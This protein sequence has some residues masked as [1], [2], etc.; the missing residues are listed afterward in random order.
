MDKR[1]K[2]WDTFKSFIKPLIKS[3][4]TGEI[5]MKVKDGVI[6]GTYATHIKEMKRDGT[7]DESVY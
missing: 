6:G 4:F 1:W 5:R 2:E 7:P 3:Y